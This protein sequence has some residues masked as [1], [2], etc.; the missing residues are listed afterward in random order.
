MHLSSRFF[1][2]FLLGTLSLAALAP[3]T[4]PDGSSLAF[5]A[6]KIS[7]SSIRNAGKVT[8]YLYRGSQPGLNDLS[9][10]KKLG[11]TTMI[12]LRA[13]SPHTAEQERIRAEAMGIHFLR[14]PMSGFS[15]P[16]N[17]DLVRFF[18]VLRDSPKQTV[19][20]H[21]EFGQDRTGVM[22]AT[23]RIAFENWPPDEAL[24]EMMA[25]GF[26]RP[27]HPS[28]VAYVRGLPN[29]LQS[30]AELKKALKLD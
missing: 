10:L 26:N 22:I 9:E 3:R 7:I 30:D 11:V 21:C 20:V 15:T 24:T 2:L 25:F 5:S 19:F 28:M 27:W 8:E 14:I 29:R 16:T 12:D 6:K 23:Y 1:A 17:S 18:Q 13:E 4:F